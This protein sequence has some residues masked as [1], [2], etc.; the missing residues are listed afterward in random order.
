D[1]TPEFVAGLGWAYAS[2]LKLGATITMNRDQHRSSRMLKRG[3]MSGIVSAG[4][5]VADLSQAPLPIGRF[6]TRRIG[7]IGGVHVRI[8][9][10]DVRVCDLKFFDRQALDMDKTQERKVETAFFRE[11][12]RRV[13]YGDVGAIF[14]SARVTPGMIAVPGFAPAGLEQ[15]VADA[16]GR[17]QRVR[18][19]A[20]AQM[21]IAVREHPLVVGDGVGGFIFPRF[22]PSFDGLFAAVRLLELLAVTNKTFAEIMD[23]TPVSNVARV[24][25]ACPW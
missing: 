20:S 13:P 24:Q 6:H 5:H 4:V 19:S 12:F 10:F 15:L 3:L 9:P 18:A 17:V 7:A 14:E 25:V 16:G 21:D 1:L 23:E 8:S 11:D 22:H 2:T